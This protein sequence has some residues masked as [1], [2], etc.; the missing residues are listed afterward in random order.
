MDKVLFKEL[1][2]AAGTIPQVAYVDVREERFGRRAPRSCSSRSM[3][4]GLPVF[5]K[6]AHLGSSVGIVKVTSESELLRGDRVG[7]RAT[8][9]A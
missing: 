4:L 2:A 5:V 6:P 1:M 9:R 7:V 8:T 3:R